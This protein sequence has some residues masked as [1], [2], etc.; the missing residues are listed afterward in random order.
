MRLGTLA[1][2]RPTSSTAAATRFE[3]RHRQSEEVFVGVAT[4]LEEYLRKNS[5][6]LSQETRLAN[7]P[8]L[9]PWQRLEINKDRELLRNPPHRTTTLTATNSNHSPLLVTRTLPL[10]GSTSPQGTSYASHA[11]VSPL[12]GARERYASTIRN[13]AIP[14]A[15]RLQCEAHPRPIH[16]FQ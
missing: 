14:I 3:L 7:A 1:E 6:L 4:R 11:S 15:P 8:V 9:A 13:T 12:A 10:N 5:S 2:S 16:R